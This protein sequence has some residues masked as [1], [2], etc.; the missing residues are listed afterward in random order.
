MAGGHAPTRRMPRPE[1]TESAPGARPWTPGVPFSPTQRARGA[2]TFVMIV[3]EQD[4]RTS[5]LANLELLAQQRSLL[6]PSWLA[7]KCEPAAARFF[8]LGFPTMQQ[9]NWRFTNVE[10]IATTQFER[11]ND[12]GSCPTA[13]QLDQFSLLPIPARRIV[14]INGRFAREYSTTAGLPE[15]VRI[16]PLSEVMDGEDEVVRQHLTRHAAY[17]NDPFIALNT[18][19]FEDGVFIHVSRH[20]SVPEPIHLLNVAMPSDDP[21]MTH[22]RNLVVCEEGG[23]LTLIEHGVALTD[24]V[25]FANPVTEIMAG[26]NARVNHYFIE[27]ESPN[28]FNVSSLAIHQQRDSRVESHTVLLGG[29]LVR[30]NIHPLLNG[31]GCDCLINGVYIGT[32]TQHLDNFMFVEHAKPHCNSRQFYKGILDHRSHG[33][34]SGRIYVAKTAQKTDAKQTNANLLL[35]DNAQINTKPQLEIYADDV[36]CTHGATVGQIDKNSVFYLRSR[37]ISQEAAR[38][39]VI[40]A[41][42][43]ESFERMHLPAIRDT[44]GRKLLAKL[45]REESLEAIP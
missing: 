13:D 11:F 44:L 2:E 4:Q 33:V 3:V 27:E 8:E 15:G 9:E 16:I 20:A 18:A 14:F 42:A 23:E 31:E 29:A 12:L 43:C 30:N 17:E 10:S 36:K 34:F 45:P 1:P 24:G 19:L 40:Y 6:V 35:S 26:A 37:G 21:I 5:N 32:E 22:P 7:A 41:F 38:A 25:Y 28:A 39:M